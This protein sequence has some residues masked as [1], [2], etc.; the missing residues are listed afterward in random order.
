MKMSIIESGEPCAAVLNDGSLQIEEAREWLVMRFAAAMARVDD[1]HQSFFDGRAEDALDD[2]R[3]IREDYIDDAREILEASRMLDNLA[4]TSGFFRT[5]SDTLTRG[6]TL[7]AIE[8][9]L[10]QREATALSVR[11]QL[12]IWKQ[13]DDCGRDADWATR[14]GRFLSKVTRDI[15]FGHKMRLKVMRDR[16]FAHVIAGRDENIANLLRVNRKE[17]A[18]RVHLTDRARAEMTG[19]LDAIKAQAPEILEAVYAARSKAVERF[20]A[21]R[22]SS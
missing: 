20:D 22:A 18:H 7:D 12:A 15:E 10:A 5:G 9:F 8:A 11:Q 3:Q 2:D 19:V 13:G 17:K 16:D 14:A 1:N 21:P 6:M 4:L